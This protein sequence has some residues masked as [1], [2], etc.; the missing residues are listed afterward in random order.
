MDRKS[1]DKVKWTINVKAMNSW[2]GFKP[3]SFNDSLRYNKDTIY[4]LRGGNNRFN[5]FMPVFY[6][7]VFPNFDFKNFINDIP[8]SGHFIHIEQP[9]QTLEYLIKYLDNMDEKVAIRN[10]EAK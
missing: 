1:K 2:F 5:W 3:T 4:H 6:T 8:D 7:K 9:E 10:A